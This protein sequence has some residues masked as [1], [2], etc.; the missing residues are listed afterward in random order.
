MS[1]SVDTE[2]TLTLIYD[3]EIQRSEK[4]VPLNTWVTIE[5][6]PEGVTWEP[7]DE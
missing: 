7:R 4:P 3:G 1:L 2:G 5:A 6:T